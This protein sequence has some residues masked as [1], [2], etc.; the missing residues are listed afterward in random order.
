M[1]KQSLIQRKNIIPV[2][3]S[4]YV[5]LHTT[6]NPF[7]GWS[8]LN[9]FLQQLCSSLRLQYRKFLLHHFTSSFEMIA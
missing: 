2:I 8:V 9:A 1:T 7:V 6:I 5:D 3:I 4:V